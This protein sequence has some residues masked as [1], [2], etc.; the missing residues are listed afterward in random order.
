MWRLFLWLNCHVPRLRC[1]SKRIFN[2]RN[3]ANFFYELSVCAYGSIRIPRYILDSD[4]RP[5]H[6]L[7]WPMSSPHVESE[8][9]FLIVFKLKGSVVP[10]S[11]FIYFW[12][13]MKWEKKIPFFSSVRCR[14]SSMFSFGLS[15]LRWGMLSFNNIET[16]EETNI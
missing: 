12:K 6:L 14:F 15:F 7:T 1:N 3:R 5:L 9:F 4:I 8:L 16:R 10:C 2:E 13:G 11:I